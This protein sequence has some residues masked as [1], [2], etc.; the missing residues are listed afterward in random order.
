MSYK[1]CTLTR[2][3]LSTDRFSSIFP[4]PPTRPW[5]SDLVP[6]LFPVWAQGPIWPWESDLVPHLFPAWAQGPIWP[7]ESDLVPHL[8]PSW[9]RGPPWPDRQTSSNRPV[10]PPCP[11]WAAGSCP[12]VWPPSCL[13]DTCRPR[14]PRSMPCALSPCHQSTGCW[15]WLK[16]E[17]VVSNGVLM[18][19]WYEQNNIL[20]VSSW[21]HQSTGRWTWLKTWKGS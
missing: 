7:W 8:C 19:E 5:E 3:H 21:C 9:A 6:H 10:S 18:P 13:W 15:M 4:A 12:A 2:Y 17:R 1:F 14:S 20:S 11:P 16:R